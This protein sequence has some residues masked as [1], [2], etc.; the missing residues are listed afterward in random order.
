MLLC[1]AEFLGELE[2]NKHDPRRP[3][4]LLGSKMSATSILRNKPRNKSATD[5]IG[6]LA[7]PDLSEDFARNKSATRAQQ[8][9]FLLRSPPPR[10][11]ERNN[12]QNVG[13]TKREIGFRLP[14]ILRQKENDCDDPTPRA[15]YVR[16]LRLEDL[17]R[18]NDGCVPVGS[19][20]AAAQMGH[21]PG[22]AGRD[23]GLLL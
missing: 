17:P 6:T 1:A 14:N 20:E 10:R 12:T 11:G 15:P 13:A 23:A 2:R 5:K 21:R 3:A 16:Q 18:P 9:C 19:G 8:R 4:Q 22:E 7:I